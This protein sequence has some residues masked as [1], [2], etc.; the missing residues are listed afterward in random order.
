MIFFFLPSNVLKLHL[1]VFI[2][3]IFFDFFLCVL[4]LFI[5]ILHLFIPNWYRTCESLVLLACNCFQKYFFLTTIF[6]STNWNTNLF[7]W[8][9]AK[10]N[11]NK[12][13]QTENV[14]FFNKISEFPGL[15][16]DS[17]WIGIIIH[18]YQKRINSRIIDFYSLP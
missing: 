11:E 10:N 14:F 8:N 12:Y 13:S 2:W 17:K 6:F 4:N 5:L 16:A 7:D 9:T 1:F 15:L 18:F 3:D